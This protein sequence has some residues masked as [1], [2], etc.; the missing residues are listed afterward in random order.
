M[1]FAKE[2][3]SDRD[4]D[5]V[6]AGWDAMKPREPVQP[7]PLFVWPR[8]FGLRY[9]IRA[10]R[11]ERAMKASSW[12][13]FHQ[14]YRQWMVMIT[15]HYNMLAGDQDRYQNPQLMRL[16]KYQMDAQVRL[17]EKSISQDVWDRQSRYY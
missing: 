9:F 7:E 13:F 3:L 10:W 15:E 16:W 1:D 17:R 12:D 8:R 4:I 11:Y 6:I 5:L 14:Y 2:T